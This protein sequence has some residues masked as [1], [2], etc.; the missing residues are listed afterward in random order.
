MLKLL[1]KKNIYIYNRIKK[2]RVVTMVQVVLFKEVLL[3]LNTAYVLNIGNIIT[4]CKP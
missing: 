1:V 4:F 2:S 3:N